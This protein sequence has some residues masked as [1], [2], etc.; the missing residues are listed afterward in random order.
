MKHN[1][2]FLIVLVLTALPVFL[3]SLYFARWDTSMGNFTAELY[4]QIVPVTANNF[5]DLANS[6][7]YNDLIFHR[8]VAGFVIQDGCPYGT[9]YGGPGYTIPDEF[10]PLLHHDQAGILAM[11]RTSAP[12]SAGSQYY[13]TL[14]PTP[15]LDGAYAIFGK[16]IEGLDVVMQIGLVPVG[17]NNL[18]LTPVNIYTLDILDLI[19]GEAMPPE[20]EV[21]YEPGIPLMFYVEAY[22]Y[23]SAL[24]FAWYVDEV[25]IQDG[26]NFIFEHNFHGAGQHLLQ[27]RVS[28]DE[29]AHT[30]AWQINVP[31]SNQ[32]ISIPANP[33]TLMKIHPNPFGIETR[34][35]LLSGKDKAVRVSIHN[36]RG[37]CIRTLETSALKGAEDV[38]WDG[39]MDSGEE[40]PSGIYFIRAELI[41]GNSGKSVYQSGKVLKIR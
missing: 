24:N 41:S 25:L 22:A 10:S 23:N 28:S 40:A 16:V 11:A 14:A 19:I 33:T 20:G 15:H 9:G 34:I 17:A 8:V 32:D 21:D 35:R 5:I 26:D 13:I 2:S 18:P 1:R 30:L 12:N 4:D 37:Q 31:T 6:G 36:L 7:F 39:R 27:C 3:M 29:F 38:I